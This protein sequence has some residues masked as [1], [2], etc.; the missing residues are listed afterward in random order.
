VVGVRPKQGQD[1]VSEQ[2]QAAKGNGN[3]NG[4]PSAGSF[5]RPAHP[6][7]VEE[8]GV[9]LHT[10]MTA[11]DLETH[12]VRA[13]TARTNGRVQALRV[14]ILGGRIVLHGFAESYHAVQLAVAGLLET[15][16]AMDLD[17]PGRI[18]LNIDVLPYRPA[19]PQA[20]S[21]RP[22]A[23]SFD[24]RRQEEPRDEVPYM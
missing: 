24:P 4:K 20:A 6:T 10:H 1:L 17:H 16:K 12:M 13:I 8:P 7:R 22:D 15:I 3:G 21:L 18:D 2:D 14:Q 5:G 11:S 23:Q 9:G 19:E